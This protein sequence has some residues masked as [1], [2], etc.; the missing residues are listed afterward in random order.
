MENS[1]LIPGRLGLAKTEI[2][3]S[4]RHGLLSLSRGQL[5]V[6]NGTLYFECAKSENMDSGNYAIPYQQ[7]SMIL[8]GPGSTVTHDALRLMARHG[9]QLCAVGDGGVKF[10][11]APP[12]GHIE[13]GRSAFARLHASLWSNNE[14]RLSIA[15]RMYATRFGK[16]FPHK[17]IDVLRGIEGGRIKESYKALA[18]KYGISWIGRRYDRHTPEDAD[19]PNQAIN[20]VATFVES[21]ANIAVTAVGALPQLGFIHETAGDAFSLDIADLYRISVTVPIAFRVTRRVNDRKDLLLEREC[22][23]ESASEFRKMQ[24]IPSMIEAIK[25]LFDVNDGS[26]HA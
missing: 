12:L 20:H 13:D 14:T 17:D 18:A 23:H 7:V 8:L 4:D 5:Y 22:R 2:P 19:I 24:L 6:E 15:R 3:Y 9:T 21:A 16:I 26:G 1:A 10:Y 11:T 25:R